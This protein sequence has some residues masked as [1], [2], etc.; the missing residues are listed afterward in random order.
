MTAIKDEVVFE[1][2]IKFVRVNNGVVLAT[3]RQ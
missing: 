1:I 3:T 2:A